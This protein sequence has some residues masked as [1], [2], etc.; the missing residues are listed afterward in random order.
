MKIIIRSH[1][2]LLGDV[3][4][5]VASQHYYLSSKDS[6]EQ[7][8]WVMLPKLCA[9]FHNKGPKEVKQARACCSIGFHCAPKSVHINFSLNS[10]ESKC[11]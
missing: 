11:A 1:F 6:T 7:N 9:I 5:V 10:L 8:S 2:G 3:V 4:S